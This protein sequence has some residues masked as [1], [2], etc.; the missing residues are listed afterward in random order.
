VHIYVLGT[1][2]LQRNFI[3]ILLLSLYEVVR[4]NFFAGFWSFRNYR[5][6]FRGFRGDCGTNR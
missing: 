1:K 6:Q 2:L 5:P 3:E 4:T